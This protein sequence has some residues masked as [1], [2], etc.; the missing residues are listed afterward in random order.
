MKN[1]I[2]ILVGIILKLL[3]TYDNMP[4]LTIL[5]LLSHTHEMAILSTCIVI[6]NSFLHSSKIFTVEVFFLL[7]SI[8]TYSIFR[9]ILHG[10]F[11]VCLLV[12][13]SFSASPLLM[14]RKTFD[15]LKIDFISWFFGAFFLKKLLVKALRSYKCSIMSLANKDNLS[16][17]FHVC[18]LFVCF[19]RVSVWFKFEGIYWVEVVRVNNLAMFLFYFFITVLSLVY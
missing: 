3:I 13:F 7:G 2:G 10:L 14:Y 16:S 12:L 17:Y 11:F 5:I 15:F 9:A 4:N 1:D 19:S 8:D 6:F 18:S